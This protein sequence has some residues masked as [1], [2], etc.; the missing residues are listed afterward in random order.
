MQEDAPIQPASGVVGSRMSGYETA[1]RRL[2]AA[3]G[4]LQAAMTAKLDRLETDRA[5]LQVAN[6]SL[7]RDC[8][9]LRAECD[10]LQRELQALS[11]RHDRLAEATSTVGDRLDAAIG[12][13]ED[14]MGA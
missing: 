6:E 5:R 13:L 8:E 11:Q 14:L 7:D 4:R 9:L 1:E 10:R 3:L 2:T 12:D